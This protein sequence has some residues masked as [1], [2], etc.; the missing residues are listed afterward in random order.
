[1]L[2]LDATDGKYIAGKGL[3]TLQI[4]GNLALEV[5]GLKLSILINMY[6]WFF[7]T[8]NS[9]DRLTWYNLGYHNSFVIIH[10]DLSWRL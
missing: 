3:F 2:I 6:E 5:W 9:N 1:M 4:V 8:I 7:E 10:L